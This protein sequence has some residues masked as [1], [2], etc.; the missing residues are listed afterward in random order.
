MDRF[1]DLQLHLRY[2]A[3]VTQFRVKCLVMLIWVFSGFIGSMQMWSSKVFYAAAPPAPLSIG[4][5]VVNFPVYL[6]ICLIVR[7]RQR[8]IQ[9]QQQH[10]QQQQANNESIFTVTRLKKSALNTFLVYILFLCCC[11]PFTVYLA[12]GNEFNFIEC[13]YHNSQFLSKPIIVLLERSSDSHGCEATCLRLI[14]SH[15][16]K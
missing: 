9:Q 15:T 2:E 5:L 7:R 8:Q 10:Q 16:I 3:V 13:F 12:L 6:R 1:L 11:L 14:L 4:F